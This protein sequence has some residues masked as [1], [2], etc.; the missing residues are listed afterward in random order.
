MCY[1]LLS[2]YRLFLIGTNCLNNTFYTFF[3]YLV[4]KSSLQ[5]EQTEPL[6]QGKSRWEFPLCDQLTLLSWAS[7]LTS[8]RFNSLLLGGRNSIEQAPPSA[9]RKTHF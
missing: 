9:E 6:E 7:Y 5:R 8:P 4:E 2:I 3:Y 1:Y